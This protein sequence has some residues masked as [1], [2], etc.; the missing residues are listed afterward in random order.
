MQ[1]VRDVQR[2]ASVQNVVDGVT[3]FK[4]ALD[5]GHVPLCVQEAQDVLPF[6]EQKHISIGRVPRSSKDKQGHFLV[7]SNEAS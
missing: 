5:H 4:A 2:P 6:N 7:E 1:S 3:R